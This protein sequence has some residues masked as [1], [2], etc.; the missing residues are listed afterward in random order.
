[1]LLHR[2]LREVLNKTV[3]LFAADPRFVAGWLS[4]SA[5]GSGEDEY[6]DVDPIFLIRDE[7]FEDIDRELP[8]VFEAIC[9]KIVLWWPE[10]RD[11]PALRN[12][13][14]LVSE[15]ELLQYD[16]NLLKLSAF[17][18][19]WLAGIGPEQVLFDKTGVVRGA[20]GTAG[21]QPYSPDDLLWNVEKYWLYVY[22]SA[23]YLR[24]RDVFKL[25]YAQ[26][27]LFQTHLAILQAL[28]PNDTWGW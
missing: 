14:V 23:K 26:G 10:I 11:N 22:I 1:L 27:V 21:A 3:E 24:R 13:A 25:L 17:S 8:S 12:Y 4:G 9:S 5:G 19:G 16:I 18:P 6:S 2:K 7:S 15:P 20:L 28:H